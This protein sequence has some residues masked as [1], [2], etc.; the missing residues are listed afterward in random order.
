MLDKM[1][2]KVDR[3]DL[4]EA[5]PLD[6]FICFC[7]QTMPGPYVALSCSGPEVYR[8]RGGHGESSPLNQLAIVVS[9][10]T[11]AVLLSVC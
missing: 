8:G 9:I 1:F 3:F 2:Y 4:T 11:A 6:L 10:V 7:S 5:Y